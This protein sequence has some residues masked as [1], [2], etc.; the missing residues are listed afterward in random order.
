M[1]TNATLAAGFAGHTLPIFLAIPSALPNHPFWVL[2]WAEVMH[3]EVA[4]CSVFMF[5]AGVLCS[6][7]GIGGGGI[8]VALL[9]ISGKLTPHD[10]VPL[11]KAIVFL[12]AIV[13]LI[14]NL[15]REFF[16]A[17]KVDECG[18]AGEAV[19]GTRLS[20]TRKVQVIDYGVCRVVVPAALLGTLVGVL[21]NHHISPIAL[22]VLLALVLVFMTWLVFRTA[23][24]QRL[25]EQQAAEAVP[26]AVSPDQENLVAFNNGPANADEL[27]PLVSTSRVGRNGQKLMLDKATWMW[28]DVMLGAGMLLVV[29]ICGVLRFHMYACWTELSGKP[30]EESSSC[31]H[32]VAHAI[33]GGASLGRLMGHLSLA[34]WVHGMVLLLPIW[35]CAMVMLFQGFQACKEE[36]WTLRSVLMYQTMAITTGMLAG[37]VGVGG[38]LIFSPF[39]LITGMDPAVAVGTSSTCVIFTSSS[40]SFQYLLTDRIIMS[41]AG[42]YGAVNLMASWL[43]TS[44]VHFLQDRF[45][46]QKSYITLIVA[47]G[48]AISAGLSIVKVVNL[49]STPAA[50]ATPYI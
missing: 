33:L 46:M 21:L 7:A 2:E 25:E 19:A 31:F 6:A 29:V 8:Y 36:R 30:A 12:G 13:S 20:L 24:K 16:A 23:Y 26:A 5:V 1:L 3:S 15:K 44:L 18:P 35:T 47:A 37:L 43:G 22:V 27:E 9:M 38:G 40:T 50:D 11:S 39:F 49:W 28:M 48:V 41:L 32:P 42:I 45:A 17:S 34:P 4:V 14:L 10:A